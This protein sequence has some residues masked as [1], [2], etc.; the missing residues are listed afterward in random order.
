[1]SKRE[2]TFY[3]TCVN[4]LYI[5]LLSHINTF[6]GNV[7][8][9]NIILSSLLV[10]ISIAQAKLNIAS[11][12]WNPQNMPLEAPIDK[13]EKLLWGIVQL[14]ENVIKSALDD[15]ADIHGFCVQK[16]DS[17]TH[18]LS[19]AVFVLGNLER[20]PKPFA[21]PKTGQ[22]FLKILEL[23]FQHG[24]DLNNGYFGWGS[25]SN[26]NATLFAETYCRMQ[27]Q[28]TSWYSSSKRYALFKQ[29]CALIKKYQPEFWNTVEQ[30]IKRYEADHYVSPMRKLYLW[31]L[32]FWLSRQNDYL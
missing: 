12:A 2:L 11:L 26:S 21:D 29:T 6:R 20:D 22:Q 15:G 24:L 17:T 23:L 14:E 25:I 9:R 31:C 16:E 1:M 5:L 32:K 7:H 13:Q 8:I 27:R 4:V 30:E 19:A 28:E 3:T 10:S 18:D